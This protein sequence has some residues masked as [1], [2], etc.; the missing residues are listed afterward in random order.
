M[1]PQSSFVRSKSRVELYAIA[2]VDL[3][4]ALIV[5][6]DHTELDDPLWDS[7]D[8]ESGLIFWVFLEEQGVLE[9]G[10]ELYQETN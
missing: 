7:S 1:E 8:L 3:H 10:D 9:G 4:L 6:P 5:F 2:T